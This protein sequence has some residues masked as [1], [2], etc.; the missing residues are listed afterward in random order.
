MLKIRLVK[1]TVYTWCTKRERERE[2][3]REG[4]KEKE[5]GNG[6]IQRLR[7][8]KDNEGRVGVLHIMTVLEVSL[9]FLF[10]TAFN[11]QVSHPCLPPRQP[12]I[13]AGLSVAEVLCADLSAMYQ[14]QYDRVMASGV[15]AFPLL[16]HV[17]DSSALSLQ[18]TSDWTGW[19][20]C[21]QHM[22]SV[23]CF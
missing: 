5:R 22:V 21:A 6:E 18:L 15:S 17:T 2:R 23:T 20:R 19:V 1:A 8:Q 14:V 3:E 12:A 11:S 16:F 4:E 9:D 10:C 13:L 7:R